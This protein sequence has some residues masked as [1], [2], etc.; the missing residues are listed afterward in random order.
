[1]ETFWYR[2]TQVVVE[3][4]ASA[5]Y[6]LLLHSAVV[7]TWL[8]HIV[9][10]SSL[11]VWHKTNHGED[12]EPREHAGAAVDARNDQRVPDS[13]HTTNYGLAYHS[14]DSLNPRGS[15]IL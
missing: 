8:G 9:D 15:P 1:M 3:E 12:D 2:F 6:K 14:S 11:L 7:L 10:R 13:S 5:L 4:R